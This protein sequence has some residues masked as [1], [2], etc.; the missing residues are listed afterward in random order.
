M[1]IY[2]SHPFGGQALN[3]HKIEGIIKQLSKEHPNNIFISPIHCFGFLY[4]DTDYQTGLNMCLELLDVCD[5]M[6]VFGNYLDSKGCKAEIQHCLD[7]HKPF[8]IR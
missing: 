2:I 4:N 5:E 7:S 1:K 6:W 8:Y 3:K